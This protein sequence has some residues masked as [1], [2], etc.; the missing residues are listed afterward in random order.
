MK[1]TVLLLSA[2]LTAFAVV[3]CETAGKTDDA[4]TQNNEIVQVTEAYEGSSEET[5]AEVTEAAEEF[6]I[7]NLSSFEVKSADLGDDGKWKDDIGSLKKKGNNVSPQL[8][9]DPVEGAGEYVIYMIDT[10]AYNW[11]HWKSV[12]KETDLSTG[13]APAEEYK[14]PYPPAGT[15]D[16]NYEVYVFALKEPAETVEGRFDT[17]NEDFFEVIKSLDNGGGNVIS[18]G[19]IAGTYAYN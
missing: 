17:T 10:S 11:M 2:L 6:S 15:G 4:A 13:W 9:W 7:D 19:R 1:K 3:S 18:Y 8:S 5:A 12:S 14:G 16:H